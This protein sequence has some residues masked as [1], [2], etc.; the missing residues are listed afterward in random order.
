MTETTLIAVPCRVITLKVELGAPSGASALERLVLEAVAG[1]RQTVQELGELFVLPYRM[2]LDV[3]HG[4]WTRGFLAVDFMTNTLESTHAAQ[5]VLHGQEGGRQ[6][7]ATKVHERKFLFDPVTATILPYDKGHHRVQHGVLEMPHTGGISENDLPQAELLR[8]VRRAVKSTSVQVQ[9]VTFAN[10]VLSPADSVCYWEVETEVKS[11]PSGA[12]TAVPVRRPPG[13]GRR[14]VELF[15][16]RITD[17]VDQRPTSRFVRTLAKRQSPE[18]RPQDSLRTMML[19]LER[20]SAGLTAVPDEEVDVLHDQL[21]TRADYVREQLAEGRRSRCSVTVVAGES[22]VAWTLAH[23]VESAGQQV[24]L[25]LPEITY[26]RL[27]SLLDELERAAKRGVTLVFLWGS[28]QHS[29]LE[30]RVATALFDFQSRYPEQILLER[31]SS[32]CAA[33]VVIC[34]DRSA[35]VGSRGVL[36]DDTGSGILVEPTAGEDTPPECVTDLLSWARRAYPY[37]A[38]GRN[39]ALTP[40]EFGRR[41][42]PPDVDSMRAEQPLSPLPVLAEKWLE[43]ATA[44]RTGW[45]AEWGRTLQELARAVDR[46]YQGAQPVV[47]AVWDG[48]YVDLTRRLV[49]GAAERLAVCDDRVEPEACG[50]A[51]AQR[52]TRLRDEGRT[53][54]LQHPSFGRE[55]RPSRLFA[56]LERRLAS[57][58]TLRVSRGRARAVLSDHEMVVGSHHPLGSRTVRPQSGIVPL[59]VG[60]HVS[61]GEF[62][63]SFARELGIADWFGA[64]SA[65]PPAYLPALPTLS[66]APVE[67]GP[68]TVLSNRLKR[69]EPPE[70]L[71]HESARLLMADTGADPEA[72]TWADWLLRDAWS[73][74][75]F[76]EAR[77]LAPL[78]GSPAGFPADLAAVAA[79]LEHGPLEYDLYASTVELADAPPGSRTV[80]LAGALAEMLQRGGAVGAE[81]CELLTDPNAL[82]DGLPP[83]WL[84]LGTA[85]LSCFRDEPGPLPLHDAA[86]WAARQELRADVRRRWSGLVAQLADF[87]RARHHFTFQDGEKLHRELFRTGQLLHLVRE[88]ARDGLPLAGDASDLPRGEVA[89]RGE[90]DRISR[91]LGV[92]EVAW[93]NHMAYAR[94]V[95]EFLTEARELSALSTGDTDRP[96]RFP[97]LTA[98]QREFARH[99]E[100]DWHHLLAEADALGE[101]DCHPARALLEALSVLPKAGKKES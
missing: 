93:S 80:A 68:W 64:G 98:R 97:V 96:R 39:I 47:R 11:S 73:R 19:E 33:S 58:R 72:K 53:V 46:M 49:S 3:V 34:D 94:K 36:D 30:D 90:L 89:V 51:L 42:T 41:E 57:E 23:L 24:V 45:V 25:A 37:W 56:E 60:L 21:R 87:E 28:R 84:R 85:A 38:A 31:R 16:A 62:T 5:A 71:R 70:T 12:L 17:L 67:D 74:R 83:A 29:K 101:P 14:A 15:Q 78:L 35:Y 100:G 82:G 8:A 99:L 27:L 18:E 91:A 10:P 61:G 20:L 26:D 66:A 7:L 86:E 88:R 1:G 2:M 50:D 48:M 54:H 43:D 79:P 59:E 76:M 77:L 6:A 4:L 69:Q 75:A 52:L 63:A 44:Y 13:W 40:A 92:R 65:T 55:H 81:V 22:G 32:C 95:S 9:N